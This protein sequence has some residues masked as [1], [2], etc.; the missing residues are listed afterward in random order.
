MSKSDSKLNNII[1]ALFFNE[2]VKKNDQKIMLFIGED[3]RPFI[4][5]HVNGFYDE[6]KNGLASLL[7]NSLK[8]ANAYNMPC[9]LEFKEL[10]KIF[11]MILYKRESN[12]C[13][14]S[15]YIKK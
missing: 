4:E 1:D 2:N 8:I 11:L 3:D 13:W 14:F 7:H 9:L 5:A 10:Q 12:L 15:P 6:I